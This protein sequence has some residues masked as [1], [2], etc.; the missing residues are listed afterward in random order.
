MASEDQHA[1]FFTP[2]GGRDDELQSSMELESEGKSSPTSAGG[3]T[4]PFEGSSS[5]SLAPAFDEEV[6]SAEGLVQDGKQKVHVE[7]LLR[8]S[9]AAAPELVEAH[10]LNFLRSDTERDAFTDGEV[11]DFSANPILDSHILRATV[12]L[13]ESGEAA[14]AS[15]AGAAASA[16]AP[17]GY[18]AALAELCGEGTGSAGAHHARDAARGVF[19]DPGR[20]QGGPVAAESKV[21]T[22]S[23][24]EEEEDEDED[25]A[26][27]S[28][29]VYDASLA[30]HVYQLNEE[31]PS[32]EYLD[33]MDGGG[34]GGGGGGGLSGGDADVSACTQ[35][36]LPC[37]EFE[38]LWPNLVYDARGKVKSRLLDY[39]S[40]ALLF[41]DRG[42]DADVVSWNR[43][44][45]LHGPPGTGKTSL[46]KAL[47]QKLSVRLGKR[48]SSAQVRLFPF[49]SFA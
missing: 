8:A 13:D 44:V 23:Y 15:S 29:P 43:V 12:A 14:S 6:G 11:V 24:L 16:G 38:G 42:V 4:A 35:W 7:V 19:G 2:R 33:D 39:V 9:S 17:A 40:S 45:L 36:V 47:A 10:V 27:L 41:G 32:D 3:T 1:K 26:P 49:L 5:K 21:G 37:S 34:G 30:V 22:G 28:I 31:G 20:V 48:F 18:D 25:Y 46:C